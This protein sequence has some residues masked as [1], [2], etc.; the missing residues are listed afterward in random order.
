MPRH[1]RQISETG[2]YHAYFEGADK[3]KL[4]PDDEDY[5]RLLE[6][7]AN[8][9]S[10][11]NFQV[12]AYCLME[13]RVHLF[14]DEATYGGISLIMNRLMLSYAKRFNA[15]YGTNGKLYAGRFKSKP[16]GHSDRFLNL[17]RYIHQTP[18]REGTGDIDYKYSSFN[19]YKG[20]ALIIDT[21][22]AYILMTREE[23]IEFH[24]QPEAEEYLLTDSGRRSDSTVKHRIEDEFGVKVDEIKYLS[25]G[26]RDELIRRL[27]RKYSVRQ[28]SRVCGISRGVIGSINEDDLLWDIRR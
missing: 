18:V 3:R 27:R 9:K 19:E 15:K 8:L 20:D 23:F 4:F 5:G 26:R 25:A 13:N 17:I 1:A 7:L 22:F 2:F 12:F 24:N 11:L 14:I 10:E 28:L 16:V 6:I 21:H